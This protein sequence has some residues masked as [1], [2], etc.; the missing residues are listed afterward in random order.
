MIGNLTLLPRRLFHGILGLTLLAAAGCGGGDRDPNSLLNVSYD[1]TRELWKQI[2]TVFKDDYQ[3]KTGKTITIQM[4]HGGSASQARSIVDGLE[5][6][7]ATLAM[8]PDT[9]EIAKA[10]LMRKDWVDQ[11]PNQSL[12]YLSTIVFVV[13]KGNPKN[14]KDWNDLARPDIKVITPNPK[15]SGNGKLSFL[16]AWGSVVLR[17]GDDKKAEEFV[18][19]LYKQV[20]VL[21]TGARGATTTFAQ[22]QIGDVHLTWENEARLEVEEYAGQLEIIYP[23]ISILAQPYVAIVDANVDL[24]GT[25][26]LAEAYL[27]YLYT[28][29]AQE[30]IAKNYYRPIDASVLAAH[31]KD[32]PSLDLFDITKIAASWDAA[33]E[34]FFKDGGVFDSIYAKR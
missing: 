31:A 15:T 32:F 28:T 22:K 2:N 6:D 17:G 33:N 23:P 25:R 18:S 5:A 14:V 19:Q 4:S 16:A 34:R 21:D 30:I 10:G 26:P 8:Y 13:R 24:H 12:P 3:Q 27:K 11:L 20:P 1:P 9:N 29:Q 7:V